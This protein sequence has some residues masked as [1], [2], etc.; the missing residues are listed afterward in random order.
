MGVS[1]SRARLPTYPEDV[2]PLSPAV[3]STEPAHDGAQVTGWWVTY[4]VGERS[5]EP[6]IP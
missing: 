3:A 2:W 6:T 5:K 1:A 4:K